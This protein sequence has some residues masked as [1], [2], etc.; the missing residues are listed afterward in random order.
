MFAYCFFVI[1]MCLDPKFMADEV[2]HAHAH[3][4]VHT[5]PIAT[6]PAPW[7]TRVWR[8]NNCI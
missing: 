4:R 3:A 1:I 6:T 7:S 8:G 2:I 5:K